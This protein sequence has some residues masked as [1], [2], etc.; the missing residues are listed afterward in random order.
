MGELNE[1]S[2]SRFNDRHARSKSFLYQRDDI[3]DEIHRMR[4]K[5][6][7]NKQIEDIKK[8]HLYHLTKVEKEDIME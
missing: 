8:G 4:L 5:M 7:E 1:K 6:A 2:S 3:L